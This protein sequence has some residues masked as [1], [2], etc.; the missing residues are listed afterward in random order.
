MKG[1]LLR[2][3]ERKSAWKKKTY[4]KTED[5]TICFV[6]GI[7]E[8]EIKKFTNEGEESTSLQ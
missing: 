3:G 4:Q 8:I 6:L 7:G 2:G 5:L 1:D